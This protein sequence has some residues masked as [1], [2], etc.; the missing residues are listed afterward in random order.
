MYSGL[1]KKYPDKFYN[2]AN[3]ADKGLILRIHFAYYPFYKLSSYT[4]SHK[5]KNSNIVI[6][7]PFRRE[8]LKE[9]TNMALYIVPDSTASNV[10]PTPAGYFSQHKMASLSPENSARNPL[11]RLDSVSF[12]RHFALRIFREPRCLYAYRRATSQR[13]LYAPPLSYSPQIYTRQKLSEALNFISYLRYRLF[14]LVCGRACKKHVIHGSS[15]EER[16]ARISMRLYARARAT[17]KKFIEDYLSLFFSKLRD[18]WSFT[19]SWFICWANVWSI[20]YARFK[21]PL[22][23]YSLRDARYSRAGKEHNGPS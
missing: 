14:H 20:I 18:K 23:G 22:S 11:P 15:R 2:S 21:V 9:K 4:H 7:I 5:R 12:T 17:V 10:P 13:I 8:P 3:F 1:I 16:A 19:V 6:G